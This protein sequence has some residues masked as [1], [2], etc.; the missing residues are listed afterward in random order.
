LLTVFEV[1]QPTGATP[2][3]VSV[4]VT[5]RPD[6]AHGLEGHV[7]HE[8]DLALLASRRNGNL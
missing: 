8:N 5:G 6:R 7:T 1:G 4:Y 2:H 3:V